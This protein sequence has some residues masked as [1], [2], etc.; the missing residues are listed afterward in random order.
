VEKAEALE[1][2]KKYLGELEYLRTLRYDNE[3][4]WLWHDGVNVVLEDTFG[5]DSDE[6]KEL[7]LLPRIYISGV[8]RE[9]EKQK[10]YLEDLKRY[11]IGIKII[12]KRYEIR[13][14]ETRPSTRME[15]TPKAFI[16]HGRES[17]TL[18]KVEGFLRALGVEPIVVKEQ[19]SVDKT[20][21]DKVDYYLN[22]ADFVVILATGDDVIENRRQPRQNVIHEVGLAQKTHAGKIIYLLEEGAEFPSNIRPKVWE[23]FSQDNMENVFV[24]IVRELRAFRVLK[25][26]KVNRETNV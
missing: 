5:K 20:L 10:D 16:S 19:P 23:P 11:A 7:N 9:E 14:V 24:Y 22:Q 15:P 6:Y 12:L 18:S 25:A 8:G 21:P 4:R 2:L 26:I 1:R 3:A 13:G 17:M